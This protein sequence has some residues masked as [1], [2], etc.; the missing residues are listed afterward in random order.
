MLKM[1]RI[2]RC[3]ILKMH[4]IQ[5]FFSLKQ[6]L[7]IFFCERHRYK[8]ASILTNVERFVS[9][10][11][12]CFLIRGSSIAKYKMMESTFSQLKNN[13]MKIYIIYIQVFFF[14]FFLSLFLVFFCYVTDY[15][16]WTRISIHA[17]WCVYI[18]LRAYKLYIRRVHYITLHA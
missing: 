14:L 16:H 17:I 2:I 11:F 10:F 1:H 13:D 5:F 8:H 12:M 3:G 4:F 7:Y 9:F 18:L 15:K 6:Q